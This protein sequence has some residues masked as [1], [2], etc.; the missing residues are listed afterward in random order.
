MT[1][2]SA[3]AII[4]SALLTKF[5]VTGHY[6]VDLGILRNKI[7]TQQSTWM[8]MAVE[9]GSGAVVALEDGG[10]V[11]SLGGGVGRQLKIAA[12]LGSGSGRRTCNNGIGISVIKAEGLLL[13][14]LRQ[15]WR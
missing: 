13:Q 6:E 10:G 3:G 1:T 2:S 15:R 14:W 12:A 4:Y 8:E 7:R 5:A 9:E 11:V